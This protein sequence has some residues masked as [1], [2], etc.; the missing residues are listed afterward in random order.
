MGMAEMTLAMVSGGLGFVLADGLDRFLS[1][2]NP[3]GTGAR[4]TDKFTSDGA[5]TLANTLNVASRPNIIRIASGVGATAL[6]AVGAMYSR[7]PYV[8]ASLEGMTVGAG[9]SLFKTLWNNLL[10]PLLT[11][12]DTSPASLQKNIIA[13]LYPA[14]VAA[15]INQTSHQAVG[16]L[17]GPADVG[18]FALAGDS[19]YADAAQALRRSAGVQAPD[20]A[21][22]TGGDSPY[23]S[24]AQVL[25]LRGDSPYADAAQALRREAGMG[26]PAGHGN[27]AQPGTGEPWN[28][29]PPPG[30]GPGPQ[31]RPHKDC[32][33]IGEGNQFLGFVGEAPEDKSGSAF[34]GVT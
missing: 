5:G 3:A 12:K 15:H 22:G 32:G 1:T 6:P 27:P 13:R 34:T 24:T 33:C 11:P 8:R 19:P 18:P 20:Y 17:S 31:A 30:V 14:E 2:Y 10:M 23:P 28:P 25:G 16:A 29:G 7:N 4:P 9:V 21:W 26:A